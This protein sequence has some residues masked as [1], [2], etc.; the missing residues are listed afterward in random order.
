MNGRSS[1][2]K[3]STYER[4]LVNE[5]K[6]QGLKSERA[7]GSNG[8]ALGCA[9]T[10]DLT[11]EQWR[12]QAKRRKSIPAYLRVPDGADAVAFREDHG[13]T[14]VLISLNAFLKLVNDAK[15]RS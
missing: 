8:R 5:A 11:I 3:G 4:E 6:A 9:E 12:V 1:K 2:R 15:T 7:Y 14:F 13:S 10:V